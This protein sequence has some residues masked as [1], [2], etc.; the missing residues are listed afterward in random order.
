M[1]QPQALE[2]I[3]VIGHNMDARA[4]LARPLPDDSGRWVIDQPGLLS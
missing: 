1:A 3:T 4:H 2:Q